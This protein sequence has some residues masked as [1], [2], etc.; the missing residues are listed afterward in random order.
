MVLAAERPEPPQPQE[1]KEAS[2]NGLGSQGLEPARSPEVG[3]VAGSQ[4][5]EASLA[6]ECQTR[7]DNVTRSQLPEASSGPGNL[8]D[9]APWLLEAFSGLESHDPL[10]PEPMEVDEPDPL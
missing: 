8:E 1:I 5:P 10:G 9:T 7:P 3:V 2:T 4:L 6:P